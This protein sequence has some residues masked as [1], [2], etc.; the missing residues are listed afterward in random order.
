MQADLL[1]R[2]E[3]LRYT[4]D[5]FSYFVLMWP[6]PFHNGTSIVKGIAINV[7]DND[8]QPTHYGGRNLETKNCSRWFEHKHAPQFIESQNYFLESVDGRLKIGKDRNYLAFNN[9]IIV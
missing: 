3:L 5:T 9:L 2:I 4:T 7:E 6:H 8:C 1:R